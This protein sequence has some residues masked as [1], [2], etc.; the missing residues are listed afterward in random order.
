M[1]IALIG[2]GNVATHL[3]KALR[4]AKH[5]ITSLSHDAVQSIPADSDVVVLAV[6]DA[7]IAEVASNMPQLSATIVHT[8]GATSISALEKFPR[9]GILYPCQ[10]FSK[11]DDIDFPSIP[12]LIDGNSLQVKETL[13][14]LLFSLGC[15]WSEANDNQRLHF[16]IAAV[17]ASNFTNHLFYVAEQHLKQNGLDWHFLEPLVRQTVDK[18]FKMSPK[19]AQTGPARRGDQATILRELQAIDAPEVRELYMILSERIE[20]TY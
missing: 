19:D 12:F 13:Q 16:H 17:F 6:P 4:A 3:A 15:K 11:D 9:H 2:H 20:S 10:T 5:T 14:S 7:H 18:A 8:S 1:N